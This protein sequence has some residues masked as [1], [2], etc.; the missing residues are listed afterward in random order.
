MDLNHS[1]ANSMGNLT[2]RG[3]YTASDAY[4]QSKSLSISIFIA[5]SYR[6]TRMIALFS[7]RA[8][9]PY[10]HLRVS[11]LLLT[12]LSL[13]VHDAWTQASEPQS[14]AAHERIARN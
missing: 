7:K 8:N 5:N 6:G 3:T 4:P 2:N 9:R 13:G 1:V 14:A 12:V 10:R 11:V